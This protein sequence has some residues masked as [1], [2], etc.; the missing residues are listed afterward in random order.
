MET[1]ERIIWNKIA[2]NHHARINEGKLIGCDESDVKPPGRQSRLS[3]TS[4][5]FDFRA[6]SLSRHPQQMFFTFDKSPSAGREMEAV[7]FQDCWMA[8]APSC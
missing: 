5:R 8:S 6:P 1:E 2:T 7:T 3:Q 4:L